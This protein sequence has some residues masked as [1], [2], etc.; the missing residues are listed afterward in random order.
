MTGRFRTLQKNSFLTDLPTDAA[1]SSAAA[2][3]GPFV[4]VQSFDLAEPWRADK[5]ARLFAAYCRDKPGAHVRAFVTDAPIAPPKSADAEE[6]ATLARRHAAAL[7]D[8]GAPLC[9]GTV[10]VPKPWGKE[11]WFTGYEARGVSAVRDAYCA[12]P[13]PWALACAPRRL[14]AEQPILLLKVLESSPTPVLGALYLELHRE[15]REVYVVTGFDRTV[16]PNGAG[17]IRYGMNQQL[18]AEFGDDAAFRAAFVRAVKAYETVRRAIDDGANTPD[19]AR[20]EAELRDA[21]D[22]FTTLHMLAVDDVVCVPTLVPHSL[23]HGARVIELQTPVYERQILSFAQKVATQPH[24]DTE[25]AAQTMRLDLPAPEPVVSEV[26]AT[27]VVRERIAT[28]AD[29]TASRYRLAPGASYRVSLTA[30]YALVIVVRGEMSVDT[31]M[32]R[33]ENACMVPGTMQHFLLANSTENEVT[34]LVAEPSLE[35]RPR[36]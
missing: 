26:L 17:A 19:L 28:L 15:K 12:T 7:I 18:R 21:M 13:L 10:D 34:L 4:H 6:F 22:R 11:I 31:T 14:C 27:G 24:W 33:A 29:F 8:F 2:Q 20:R 23:Q 35:G 30:A 9:L 36:E 32:L 16:W 25:A 1:L 3:P 5:R